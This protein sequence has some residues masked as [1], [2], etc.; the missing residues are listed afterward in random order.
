MKYP[1]FHH[2][3]ISVMAHDNY[4]GKIITFYLEVSVL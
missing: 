1:Y 2:T 3:T 4:E